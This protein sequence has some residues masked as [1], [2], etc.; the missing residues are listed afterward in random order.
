MV[1]LR[2]S[3]ERT[4]SLML[5]CPFHQSR[6]LGPTL[7]EDLMFSGC[8]IGADATGIYLPLKSE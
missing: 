5:Y 6:S 8:W 7:V 3:G 1:A 2:F 4:T